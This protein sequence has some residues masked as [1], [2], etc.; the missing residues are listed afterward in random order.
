MASD[1][2]CLWAY[3]YVVERE[4]DYPHADLILAI[5]ANRPSSDSAELLHLPL[6]MPAFIASVISQLQCRIKQCVEFLAES[7]PGDDVA[8]PKPAIS[9]RKSSLYKVLEFPYPGKP[10]VYYA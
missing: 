4:K 9:A 6:F 10:S 3:T 2:D 8:P 1:E 7:E 5:V